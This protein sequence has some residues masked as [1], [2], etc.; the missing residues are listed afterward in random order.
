[1]APD[2][3][4]GAIVVHCLLRCNCASTGRTEHYV[5]STAER[6]ALSYLALVRNWSI[7]FRRSSTFLSSFSIVS[8][9][10][11]SF[12][13]IASSFE[14]ASPSA[15]GVRIAKVR[16]AWAV[17]GFGGVAAWADVGGL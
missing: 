11:S 16:L 14:S 4:F 8:L 5:L 12:L 9:R 6:H 1:M 15:R 2:V 10:S 3:Q 7:S 13:I 17:G